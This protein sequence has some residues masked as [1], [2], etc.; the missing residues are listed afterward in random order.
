[1]EASISNVCNDK[2]RFFII[3]DGLDNIEADREFYVCAILMRE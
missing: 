3:V 2:W 1:M